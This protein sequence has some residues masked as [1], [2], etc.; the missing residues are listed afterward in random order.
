M[1]TKFALQAKK[2]SRHWS[3]FRFEDTPYGRSGFQKILAYIGAYA[4]CT[5]PGK[6]G[7]RGGELLLIGGQPA[8]E[9]KA[10]EGATHDYPLRDEHK[11]KS[12]QYNGECLC[13][14]GAPH[15]F[16]SNL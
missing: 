10:V 7:H 9:I 15:G 16:S 3:S 12:T 2:L 5:T 4:I 8:F 14:D 1:P 11:D 13:G 6:P